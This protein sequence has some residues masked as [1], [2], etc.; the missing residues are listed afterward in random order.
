MS[1][2]REWHKGS[3]PEGVNA[4]VVLLNVH[5]KLPFKKIQLLFSDLFGYA[6]N[7]STVYSASR[8]CYERLHETEETILSRVHEK[9]GA[10]ALTS[11]KSILD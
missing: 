3:T 7:E 1:G 2:L 4:Y 6:I 8:Q 10:L 9:R 11:D 5:F